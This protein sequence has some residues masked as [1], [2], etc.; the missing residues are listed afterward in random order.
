MGVGTTTMTMD[1]TS[2]ATVGGASAT[3]TR[4]SMGGMGNGCKISVR[5]RPA[6]ITQ[7]YTLTHTGQ[8]AVELEHRRR[9]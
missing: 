4:V 3:A 5:R 6:S 7:I 2:T 1:M 9:M 8:D